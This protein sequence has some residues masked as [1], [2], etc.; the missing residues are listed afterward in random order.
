MSPYLAPVLFSPSNE[1]LIDLPSMDQFIL[2]DVLVTKLYTLLML[3]SCY[4]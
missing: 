3:T 2:I 1:F 4:Y